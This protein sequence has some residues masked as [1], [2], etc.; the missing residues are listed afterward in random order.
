M[1]INILMMKSTKMANFNI[2]KYH[3]HL[4]NQKPFEYSYDVPRIPR[5]D[6]QEDMDQ[7]IEKLI[8]LGAIPLTNLE[9]DEWYYGNNRNATLGKWNGENFDHLNSSFNN[10]FWD[11][12][13]HF[14]NDNGF[15]L[16]TPIRKAT[17]EEIKIELDK[18]D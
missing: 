10:Y 9:V 4:D 16:F 15:A 11:T 17:Q 7:F 13:E 6:R 5:Y 2:K 14:Q 3:E 12:S 18:I 1:L 8:K